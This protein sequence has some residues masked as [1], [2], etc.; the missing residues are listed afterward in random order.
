MTANEL[1]AHD[2]S[3]SLVV[4]TSVLRRNKESKKLQRTAS[5]SRQKR[6]EFK[7]VEKLVGV[8]LPKPL[9][10]FSMSTETHGNFLARFNEL[11]FM[12]I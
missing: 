12:T 10:H 9:S 1:S 4:T 11:A 5:T 6:F 8:W 2:S 3:S 7:D